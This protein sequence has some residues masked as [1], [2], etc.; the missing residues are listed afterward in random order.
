MDVFIENLEVYNENLGVSNK[1]MGSQMK[2]WG[3]PMT[4]GGLQQDVHGG[5]SKESRSPIVVN[6]DFFPYPKK[7]LPYF[8]CYK[9]FPLRFS[10]VPK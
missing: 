5:V 7:A 1:K 4:S 9:I 8:L 6:D 10:R 3:F 2:I